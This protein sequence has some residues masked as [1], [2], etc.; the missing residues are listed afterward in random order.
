MEKTMREHRCTRVKEWIKCDAVANFRWFF[1][2]CS[3]FTHSVHE[4]GE[5]KRKKRCC[6]CKI[7]MLNK[8]GTVMVINFCNLYLWLYFIVHRV[9]MCQCSRCLHHLFWY[10]VVWMCP[11]GNWQIY[12]VRWHVLNGFF[13]PFHSIAHFYNRTLTLLHREWNKWRNKKR[14]INCCCEVK[15][16]NSIR[17]SSICIIRICSCITSHTRLF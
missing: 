10:I 12:S 8:S 1:R 2:M 5:K 17:I 9:F 6:A 16:N 4:K 3:S 14:L 11:F 13:L 7:I 15:A